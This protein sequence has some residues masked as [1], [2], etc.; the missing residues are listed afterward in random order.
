MKK[1]LKISVLLCML[2]GI[3]MMLA[4]C[5][6]NPNFSEETSP[7]VSTLS[8]TTPEETTSE[9]TTPEATTPEETTPEA[10]TPEETTP[11]TT[12]PEETTPEETTPEITPPESASPSQGLDFT[13]NGDGTCYVNGIGSCT[14]TDIVIPSTSPEGDTVV[15]IGGFAFYKIKQLTSVMI[16]N[17]VTVIST[18]A[19]NGCQSLQSVIIPDRA[20]LPSLHPQNNYSTL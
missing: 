20:T 7:E 8:S 13:S 16:P 1:I 10:T 12:T 3:I 15:K 11:E 19:F 5:N 4:A 14:D 2:L 6:K 17:S 9:E 18:F